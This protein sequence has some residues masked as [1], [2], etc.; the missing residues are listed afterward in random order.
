MEHDRRNVEFLGRIEATQPDC[1]IPPNQPIGSDDAVGAAAMVE[2]EEVIAIIIKLV[3]I[4]TSACHFRQRLG[5]KP[6]IK[7]AIPQRLRRID[8][9]G[10]FRE[11]HL[12][13]A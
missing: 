4:A 1:R 10:R 9:R 11:A 5:A 3:D 7:D 12:Q 6:L 13:R 2:D 8:I